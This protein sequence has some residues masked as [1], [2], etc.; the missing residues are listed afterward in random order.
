MLQIWSANSINSAIEDESECCQ[1]QRCRTVLRSIGLNPLP[2]K[3]ELLKAIC[4]SRGNDLAFLWC[5]CVQGYGELKDIGLKKSFSMN[6]RLILSCICHLDMT[7]TLRELDNIL[8][9]PKTKTAP[10]VKLCKS[11]AM[12]YKTP[13]DEPVPK[14]SLQPTRCFPVPRRA[15]PKFQLYQNYKNPSALVVNLANRCFTNKNLPFETSNIAEGTIG[16]QIEDLVDGNLNQDEPQCRKQ[17]AALCGVDENCNGIQKEIKKAEQDFWNAEESQEKQIIVKTLLGQVVE[18]AA[19]LKYIHLCKHCEQRKEPTV[20]E[21]QKSTASNDANSKAK[22]FKGPTTTF[23][24]EFDYDRIFASNIPSDCGVVKNSINKALD[25]C[26]HSTEDNAIESCLQDIWQSELSTWNENRQRGLK[27]GCDDIGQ[28][29]RKALR[30]L[31][32]AIDVMRKDPRF[33]L[34]RLPDVHH[35]PLLREWILHRFGIRYD[36]MYNEK[37]WRNNKNQR[38]RL[39]N[40]GLMP[41]L[42]TPSPETFG[43]HGTISIDEAIKKSQLVRVNFMEF[44]FVMNS[45][46]ILAAR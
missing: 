9:E 43:V 28:S 6:E 35:L 1:I 39:E 2:K 36:S 34:V 38:A 24:H 33:V 20:V 22:F 3:L 46:F 29:K 45:S 37:R 16:E 14:P 13:Y 21:R 8:P 12:K 42:K 31:H 19:D 27:K 23:P 5:L 26:E 30:L 32:D 15:H 17:S 44:E 18:K 4:F 7:R 40:A 11:K 41:R 25:L 10:K